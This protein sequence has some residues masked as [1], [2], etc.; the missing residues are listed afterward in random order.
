MRRGVVGGGG[1]VREGE[2]GGGGGGVGA[3]VEAIGLGEVG[4]SSCS[5][6]LV[7]KGLEEGEGLVDLRAGRQA[8]RQAGVDE[9]NT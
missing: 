9:Q 2:E 1:G 5:D 8:G 6:G 7:D 3:E 4:G